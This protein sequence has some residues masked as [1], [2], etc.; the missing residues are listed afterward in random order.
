MTS[1]QGRLRASGISRGSGQKRSLAAL[2]GL[3]LFLADVQSWLGP[4]LG[5]YLINKPGWNAA[6]VGLILTLGGAA[7]L[8]VQTPVGAL[9]DGRPAS[10]RWWS[11]PRC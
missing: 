7:G 6:S 3:N 4:F 9:V 10:G 1:E 11:P 2:D 5:I 8:L